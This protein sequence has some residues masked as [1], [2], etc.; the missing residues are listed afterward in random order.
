MMIMYTMDGCGFCAKAKQM[1]ANELNSGEM[2]LKSPAEAP[3]GVSGFPT[4]AY[5]GKMHSGLP[6]SKEELYAKL[7][8]QMENYQGS[9]WS[10]P[11]PYLPAGGCRCTDETLMSGCSATPNK[12]CSKNKERGSCGSNSSC[13][14]VDE[15]SGC[16]HAKQCGG[17]ASTDAIMFYNMKGCP[18][19]MAAEQTLA[20]EIQNGMVV[21]KDASEAPKGMFQGFPAFHNPSTNMKSLGAP[22]SYDDLLMKLSQKENYMPVAKRMQMMHSLVGV[23]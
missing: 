13:V 5:N 14:Y 15:Y 7:G 19:C 12:K 11:P 9:K 8:Y 6:S 2:M 22:K 23:I 10:G 21:M 1:F 16:N 4:F 17:T 20:R 3:P 18:H